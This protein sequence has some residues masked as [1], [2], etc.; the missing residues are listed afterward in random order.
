MSTFEE[1]NLEAVGIEDFFF[2]RE[3]SH[4]IYRVDSNGNYHS[5][6]TEIT[7]FKPDENLLIIDTEKQAV[8]SLRFFT[9]VE[10]GLSL[11]AVAAIDRFFENDMNYMLYERR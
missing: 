6:K 1:G 4:T 3:C 8:C 5:V 2:T 7:R 10:W 11:E 9:E